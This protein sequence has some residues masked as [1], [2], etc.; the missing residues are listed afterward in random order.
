M[1]LCLR[2]WSWGGLAPGPVPGVGPAG[3][4]THHMPGVARRCGTLKV[5]RPEAWQW[6]G[7][8]ESRAGRAEGLAREVGAR[9]PTPGSWDPAGCA[10]QHRAP[11]SHSLRVPGALTRSPLCWV[12]SWGLACLH[13][14]GW[15][16]AL[17]RST[18]KALRLTAGQV[19]CSRLAP[20]TQDGSGVWGQGE[21]GP[22]ICLSRANLG[23]KGL[24]THHN[25]QPPTLLLRW[26]KNQLFFTRH[27]AC[28]SNAMFT[29]NP[30]G[31]GRKQACLFK[32]KKQTKNLP[33]ATRLI[34][35]AQSKLYE[36]VFLAH[37]CG[38]ALG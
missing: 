26:H 23:M 28:A 4:A 24:S 33:W 8:M 12:G 22:A 2:S 11:T 16:S 1:G 7:Y 25:T 37:P 21:A 10:E 6:G 9:K 38:P 5:G 27:G 35:G 14:Q 17:P 3:R 20:T 30:F 29:P 31:S 36:A 32:N 34:P 13:L 18:K 15:A 19:G